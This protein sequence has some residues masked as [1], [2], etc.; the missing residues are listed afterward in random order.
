MCFSIIS[1]I[2]LTMYKGEKYVLIQSIKDDI[3]TKNVLDWIRLLT[4]IPIKRIN[5]IKEVKYITCH[6]GVPDNDIKIVS[7][8]NDIYERK[9]VLRYWY[10][11]GIFQYAEPWDFKEK[12]PFK[13]SVD[14]INRYNFDL[15][16]NYVHK[17][18]STVGINSYNDNY[19]NKLTVLSIAEDVGLNI[20]RTIITNNIKELKK[21]IA[22]NTEI[23]IKPISTSKFSAVYNDNS[24][25]IYYQTKKI[26]KQDFVDDREIGITFAQKYIEKKYEIRSFYINKEIYSMCIFSQESRQTEVDYRNYDNENPNRCVPYSLP[27]EIEEKLVLLMERLHINCGSFDLIFD[28]KEQ[29]VFLEVNPV[30]Q[31]D[32]LSQHCNY[33]IDKKIASEL[34]KE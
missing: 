13:T 18:F 10:R 11:R 20:P 1:Y 4:N 8:D 33:Y 27:K 12:I 22:N 34:I 29:Y 28:R 7:I 30:G 5:G 31:Y 6:L 25:D 16:M 15:I 9:S 3:N 21:F 2:V 14:N 23:I 19:I 32:W 26:T 17:S 24:Y